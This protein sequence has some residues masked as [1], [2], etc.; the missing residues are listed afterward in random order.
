MG[1]KSADW[2]VLKMLTWATSYFEEK[3]IRNPRLSIE[4][5]LAEVLQKKRLDLYLIYDRPLSR[6][7]LDVIKPMIKR[8]AQHEPLQYI[9]GNTNFFGTTLKVN[10]NVLIP[11]PETEELVDWILQ[12]TPLN[13]P[14]NVLDIG[15]G[16]GC[17]PIA[18]KKARSNWS[19]H[20]F[21]VSN[22]ALLTATENAFLNGTEINFWKDDIFSPSNK[23][24]AQEFNIITSN[25]P[26][27]LHSE[28]EHLDIEVKAFEPSLALFTSS[29][30]KI[31]KAIIQFSTKCLKQ[32]GLLAIEINEKFGNEV[33][34]LFDDQVWEASIQKDYGGKDRFIFAKKMK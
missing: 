13:D 14:F 33:L 21:D 31:F 7:E 8:R 29:T 10:S 24:L 23:L 28:A 9:V 34:T 18:L 25:P 4:W 32:N 3:G 12:N 20:A 30:K 27:I 17:I 22:D 26:Y 15:T 2:T 1:S 11:R 5:L 19:I 16:S 6:E